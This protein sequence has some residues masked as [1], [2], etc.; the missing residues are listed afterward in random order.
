MKKV[1]QGEFEIFTT[2]ADAIDKLRQM[3]GICRE[4]ISGDNAIEFLCQKNGEIFITNPPRRRVENDNSTVLF[5]KVVEKDGKTCV[6]YYTS[7]SKS[8]NAL[9]LI[10]LLIDFLMAAISIVFVVLSKSQM[11]YLPILVL[12]LPFFGFKFFFVTEEENN[13]Q[14]DSEILIKELE[15]RVEAVNLWD[16]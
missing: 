4:N 15:K 9:K 11:Y 16:K 3:Q 1:S 10:F 12:T 2:K 8:T 5:A 7:F 13:S 14:K 6:T